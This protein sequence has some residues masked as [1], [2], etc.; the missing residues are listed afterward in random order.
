[1]TGPMTSLKMET[2][3]MAFEPGGEGVS[4]KN[5]CGSGR[6]GRNRIRTAIRLPFRLH[7]IFTKAGAS[8]LDS[9]AR[10]ASRTEFAFSIMSLGGKSFSSFSK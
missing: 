10:I 9:I 7:F 3:V 2:A 5:R 4:W 1:M 6:A 8:V